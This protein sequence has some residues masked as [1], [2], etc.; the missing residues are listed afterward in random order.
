MVTSINNEFLPN[1]QL[2]WAS[3]NKNYDLDD[4]FFLVSIYIY[5]DIIAPATRQ[6]VIELIDRQLKNINALDI[7]IISLAGFS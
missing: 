5:S 1:I 7:M 4:I 2:S 6:K 3:L